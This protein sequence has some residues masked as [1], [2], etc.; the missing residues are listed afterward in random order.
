MS[1]PEFGGPWTQEKLD[2]LRRYL[3]AYTTALKKQPF[4]LSYIDAFAG[5]GVYRANHEYAEYEVFHKG[6]AA[7]ALDIR[8]KPFD[9][10]VFVEES[11]GRIQSLQELAGQNTG[12]DIWIL[13]GNANLEIPRLC[14]NMGSADRAVVF[15]DP[16]ATE[17]S[18]DTVKAIAGT[19]KIDCWILFP[20]MAISRMM[21]RGREPNEAMAN[22]LDRIFGGRHYWQENYQDSS[23]LPLLDSVPQ[24]ERDQGSE[25]IA[26]SY[27]GRLRSVFH[28]VAEPRRVL[29]NSRNGPL[30]ELFFAAGNPR[31]AGTA[32]E[33][34]NHILKHW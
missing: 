24:R 33:I 13:Q 21:P 8:D 25:H 6:S 27:K 12:R 22:Q 23:Q 17:V 20:L 16:Y 14:D 30:F 28:S 7:I 11:Y 3:T 26:N 1:V 18:W 34:A 5:A 4:T 19:K 29:R 31:G 15:L 10:L 2:I 9:R 32:V